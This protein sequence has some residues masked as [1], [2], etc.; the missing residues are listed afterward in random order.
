MEPPIHQLAVW[1]HQPGISALES[2]FRATLPAMN[3]LADADLLTVNL[4]I[5]KLY[6]KV[7]GVLPKLTQLHSEMRTLP[8]FDENLLEKI[9]VYSNALAHVHAACIVAQKPPSQLPALLATATEW[10]RILLSDARALTQRGLLPS[11]CLDR[12]KLRKGYKNVAFDVMALSALF[13]QHWATVAGKTAVSPD[14]IEQS[15]RIAGELLAAV[16]L[17]DH[18]PASTL[19]A[20][21]LRKRAFTLL[22]NVYDE[23]RRAVIYL[24]WHQDDVDPWMPSLYQRRG[25]GRAGRGS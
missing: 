13:R 11:R 18:G 1:V 15:A 9:D 12:L 25:S 19:C 14:D 2:A 6:T 3:T 20:I 5:P 4:D 16:G 8:G 17:R 23:L 21:E 24:R 10:R 7:R 22:V